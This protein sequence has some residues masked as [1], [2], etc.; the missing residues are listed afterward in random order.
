M[1]SLHSLRHSPTQRFTA[2]VSWTSRSRHETSLES[3]IQSPLLPG[4][5]MSPPAVRYRL[6]E[7]LESR[8]LVQK[9]MAA[10]QE[11]C[12]R[13]REKKKPGDWDFFQEYFLRETTK[14]EMCQRHGMTSNTFDMR[15]HRIRDR[16][17]EILRSWMSED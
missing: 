15:V 4:V 12:A 17:S 9:L 1:A 3:W 10:F 14:E 16:L 7:L 2:S 5:E 13:L 6:A 8:E 11:S